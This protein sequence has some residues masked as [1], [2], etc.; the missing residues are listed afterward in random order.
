MGS[1]PVAVTE[2]LEPL[3]WASVV[4]LAGQAAAIWVGAWLT[5]PP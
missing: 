4:V 2:K 5:A 3:T 1:G